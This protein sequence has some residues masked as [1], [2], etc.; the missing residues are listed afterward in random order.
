LARIAF[1]PHLPP[2]CTPSEPQVIT[3]HTIAPASYAVFILSGGL[4]LQIEHH[5]LPGVN[6]CHL[7]AL[8]PAIEAAARRHGVP[9][10]RTDSVR[11]AFAGLLAHVHTMSLKPGVRAK[12]TA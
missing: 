11:R 4:N 6:H 1:S 8:Q 5:L 3:S 10:L 9:Y 7:R 12:K 2:A